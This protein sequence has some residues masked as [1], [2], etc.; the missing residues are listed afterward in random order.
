[1]TQAPPRKPRAEPRPPRLDTA[2]ALVRRLWLSPTEAGLLDARRS[3]VRRMWQARRCGLPELRAEL[4]RLYLQVCERQ[5]ARDWEIGVAERGARYRARLEPHQVMREQVQRQGG[6]RAVG[7]NLPQEGWTP[8]A[9]P[10]RRVFHRPPPGVAAP[11]PD[12]PLPRGRRALKVMRQMAVSELARVLYLA[13][14][15]GWKSMTLTESHGRPSESLRVLSS[16]HVEYAGRVPFGTVVM[17]V[18]TLITSTAYRR[19]LERLSAEHQSEIRSY[20]R[21][22]PAAGDVCPEVERWEYQATAEAFGA[23]LDAL[24]DQGSLT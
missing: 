22:S 21:R 7:L 19:A 8:G 3:L 23:L 20:Y 4:R 14:S 9:A 5:R 10:P 17:P 2:Q 16:G 11:A 15:R 1:M 13:H 24:F 18:Q 12:L 6:G